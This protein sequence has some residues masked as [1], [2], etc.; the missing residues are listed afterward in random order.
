MGAKQLEK[1]VVNATLEE[2]ISNNSDSVNLVRGYF[3]IKNNEF[4]V[5]STGGQKPSMLRSMSSANCLIIV[6]GEI[7]K[8]RAGE[9]VPIQL[10]DHE[11]IS[12][13]FK[14]F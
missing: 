14:T 5:T 10:I 8:L 2:D 1:P 7:V 6:P 9:K 4:Y 13:A 11:E 12:G 3:T